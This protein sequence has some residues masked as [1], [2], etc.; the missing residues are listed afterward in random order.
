MDP[1]NATQQGEHRYDAMLPDV[2]AAGRAERRQFAVQTLA[3]LGRFFGAAPG[4]S[5]WR[6]AERLAAA[7]ATDDDVTELTRNPDVVVDGEQTTAFD[8][9]E[10]VDAAPAAE[11]L[12]QT[13]R[14]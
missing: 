4:V 7:G 13:R 12:V 8:V 10:G 9:T 6:F 5:T 11:I 3:E 1:V 14:S 2:S